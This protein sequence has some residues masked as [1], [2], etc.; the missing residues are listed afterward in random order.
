MQLPHVPAAWQLERA[1][2]YNTA[3]QGYTVRIQNSV[4]A[5]FAAVEVAGGKLTDRDLARYLTS[6]IKQ[7]LEGEKI[8]RDGSLA[9]R[10]HEESEAMQLPASVDSDDPPYPLSLTHRRIYQDVLAAVGAADREFF[11]LEDFFFEASKVA[12]KV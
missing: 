8:L 3:L 6:M 11:A 2:F 7:L 4:V 10:P 12:T 5:F 1:N 9:F